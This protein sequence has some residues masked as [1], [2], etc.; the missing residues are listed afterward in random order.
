ME[1]FVSVLG[2]GLRFTGYGLLPL[3]LLPLAI[4]AL[5][6]PGAL[7]AN[8]LQANKRR[9]NPAWVT[10]LVLVAIWV[11]AV[12]TI[13]ILMQLATNVPVSLAL[14][15]G[16]GLPLTG[17]FMTYAIGAI[18]AISAFATLHPNG[19]AG[20]GNIVTGILD[21]ISGVA[22]G[23]ALAA[24][25]LIIVIQ[26]AAVLLRYLFGLS[27]S[28]LNDSVIF[29][30]AMMFMLGAAAT[31]RDDGHVRVDILRPR[32]G[33]KTKAGIELFGSLLFIVPIGILILEAG[34][35]QIA[36]SWIG[37]EHF[38]ESDGLPIKYLFKTLVPVFA[39]L[40]IGQALSQA[41]KAALVIR[42]LRAPDAD[43]DH[44]AEAV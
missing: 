27:F 8:L 12:E 15:A 11:L 20:A 6:E 5:P 22:L 7:T 35:T 30:F 33:P 39:I 10:F 41:V 3:L 1:Q 16:S 28:W 38:N 18:L 21:R 34:S 17:T 2:T 36:R 29:T 4:L 26:L 24:A 32:F 31:L 44:S 23:F 42:G 9:I 19:N 40:M 25:F 13:A 43:T 37:L 14:S